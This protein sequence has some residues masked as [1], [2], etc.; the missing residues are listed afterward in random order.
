MIEEQRPTHSLFLSENTKNIHLSHV[1]DIIFYGGTLKIKQT[2]MTLQDI[3]QMLSSNDNVSKTNISVKWDGAPS[4]F[5][6]IDPEDNQFFVA[7]KSLFNKTPRIYKTIKSVDNDQKL[8]EDLARKLK[9]ALEYLSELDI[10]S[11]VFQGDMMFDSQSLKVKKINDKNYLTFHPNTLV[12]AFPINSDIAKKITK[13]KIG[14]V[15]HTSYTGESLKDLKASPGVDTSQFTETPNVWSHDANIIDYNFLID[16]DSSTKIKKYITAIKK[17]YNKIPESIFSELARDN[18]KLAN[19]LSTFINF[20]VKSKDANESSFYKPSEEIFDELLA[21]NDARFDFHKM[22]A[23]T[24]AQKERLELKQKL[25]NNKLKNNKDALKKLF[26]LHHLISHTKRIL[27]KH[28]NK[29]NKSDIFIRTKSGYR[30][31]SHEGFV[32][33]NKLNKNTIKL[34][35]R[36]EF[37]FANFSD[38]VIRGFNKT[39]K[40]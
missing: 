19:N 2:I 40:T 11:G 5:C 9:I 4:L 24:P 28:L 13:T 30:V 25:F 34:V 27:L 20:K 6:G 31:S 32:A 36:L 39:S 10:K 14:I 7:T 12:Y 26:D 21:W 18:Q 1:E 22:K 17:L 16:K 33:T 35:D 38:D 8:S 37:S 29:V 3:L 23:Q 15:W